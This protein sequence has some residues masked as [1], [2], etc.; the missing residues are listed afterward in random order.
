MFLSA[1][2]RLA[3]RHQHHPLLR[4]GLG[5]CCAL[6]VFSLVSAEIKLLF[7]RSQAIASPSGL[8]G[9]PSVFVTY[10]GLTP[11]SVTQTA[12]ETPAEHHALHHSLSKKCLQNSIKHFR[13]SFH[14][15][16]LKRG[17]GGG[18]NRFSNRSPGLLPQGPQIARTVEGCGGG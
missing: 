6:C 16:F 7:C 11:E 1:L 12:S 8:R 4:Q 3:C 17:G 5:V 18:G 10:N 15:H 2:V 14:T 13:G 9:V